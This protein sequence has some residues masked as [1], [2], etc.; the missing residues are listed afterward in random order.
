MKSKKVRLVVAALAITVMAGLF[1]GC[2]SAASDDKKATSDNTKKQE[3]KVSGSIT[4]SGSTALQPLAEHSVDGFKSKNP[5][6][7]VNVQGGGSGT[8]LSQVAQGAVD[9]GNSDIYAKDR[10]SVV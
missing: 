7:S 8:G 3:Q 5:D 2:G 9:I 6:A 10:K 4:A 1:A